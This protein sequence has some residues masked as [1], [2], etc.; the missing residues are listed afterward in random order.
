MN[1][2]ARALMLAVLVGGLAPIVESNEV[3]LPPGYS[4][5]SPEAELMFGSQPVRGNFYQVRASAGKLRE[6]YQQALPKHGWQLRSMAWL[7]KTLEQSERLE[8]SLKDSKETGQPL[9]MDQSA[10]EQLGKFNPQFMR[11]SAEEMVYAGHDAERVLVKLLPRGPSTTVVLMYRWEGAEDGSGLSGLEQDPDAPVQANPCCTQDAVPMD[12]RTLPVTMPRYPH[13]RMVTASRAPNS[14]PQMQMTSEMYM[15]PDP[16]HEVLAYYRK[17]MPLVGW[18]ES[19]S[20]RPVQQPRF[21]ESLGAVG[22][23]VN[24]STMTFRNSTGDLCSVFVG[25]N[26]LSA[27]SEAPAERTMIAIHYLRTPTLRSRASGLS[28]PP[29]MKPAGVE[30]VKP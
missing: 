30:K 23:S 12:R 29:S 18:N 2:I 28:L 26:I 14:T 24:F 20:K 11:S 4:K 3:P 9:P 6:Y 13:G 10:K 7:D 21:M 8:K 19:P 17:E 16:V 25:Q 22:E 27:G 1:A 5:P 15:T